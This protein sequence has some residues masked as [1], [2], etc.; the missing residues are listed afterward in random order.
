MRLSRCCA[1]LALFVSRVFAAPAGPDWSAVRGEIRDY[2]FHILSIDSSNPPGN[3]T[4]VV[5][6]LRSVLDKEGI[7]YETFAL[8]PARANLVVRIKGDGSQKPLLFMGHTDVVGVQREHWNSDPFQPTVKDGFIYARGASDDKDSVAAGLSLIVFLHR[9]HIPLKRDVIFLAEAGEEATSKWGV[10]FMV[11][12]HWN[13]IE[14]EYA[15]AEGGSARARNGK[16]VAVS[17]STTEKS[18]RTTYLRAHGTAGHGS[19]PRV[20]NPVSHLSAAVAQVAAHQPP[21]RLNDTT[22]TYF[23]KLALISDKDKAER[24][25][26]ITD[27]KSAGEIESYF[28]SSEPENYSM[29]RTSIVPTI[30]KAG[31]RS[32]VIPTDAE[33][34]LDIRA[35]PGENMDSIYA[36]LK[37][38]IN[39]PLVDVVASPAAEQRPASPPSPLDSEAYRTIEKVQKQLYPG[40][41]TMPVMLTGA[42]DMAQLRAKGVKAY[43]IGPAIDEDDRP[44]GG[45]HTDNE[46]LREEY[47]YQFVEF[48]WNTVTQLAAR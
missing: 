14:S 20:D 3:E 5:D 26:R 32:N 7:A 10:D 35:L 12:Q 30:I 2:Y 42:T 9:Y 17:V 22:R 29:L 40:A 24:Y 43:G 23:E 1:L 6:Y 21:A 27:P 48:L 11:S 8:D 19:V 16:I 46:R 38:V 4:K 28:A 45:A 39:D 18:P 31:F 47:L 36:Y 41:I 25:N 13:A 15:F 44:L 37:Q 34:T 33:A